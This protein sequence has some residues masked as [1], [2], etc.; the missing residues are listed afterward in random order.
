MSIFSDIAGNKRIKVYFVR[1]YARI[2]G[3]VR[4]KVI[5]QI[6]NDFLILSDWLP[7][8]KSDPHISAHMQTFKLQVEYARLFT[9]ETITL[10]SAPFLI[11]MN[12]LGNGSILA[13][14]MQIKIKD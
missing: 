8:D 9:A 13:L 14:D 6:E 7:D 5:Q 11:P 1:A 2:L 10:G 3:E 4:Y 12:L